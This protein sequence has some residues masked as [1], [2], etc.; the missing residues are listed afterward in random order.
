MKSFFLIEKNKLAISIKPEKMLIKD[1]EKG[2][3]NIK[4]E[5]KTNIICSSVDLLPNNFLPLTIEIN[6]NPKIV[7]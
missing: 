3:L 4:I 5:N 7:K 1:F 6:L 2:R